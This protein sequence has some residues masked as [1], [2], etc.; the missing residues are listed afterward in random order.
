MGAAELAALQIA[1]LDDRY[2]GQIGIVLLSLQP[3]SLAKINVPD[4]WDNAQSKVPTWWHLQISAADKGFVRN[5]GNS[6]CI[7]PS[8]ETCARPSVCTWRAMGRR[9]CRQR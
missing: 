7:T 5:G 1:V 2:A 8:A 9:H 6:P 3:A 4:E